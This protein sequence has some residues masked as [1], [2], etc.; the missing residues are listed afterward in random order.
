[1]GSSDVDEAY[2]DSQLSCDNCAG[3]ST[4]G[5]EAASRIAS[6]SMPQNKDCGGVVADNA[7][8]SDICITDSEYDIL[9]DW[10]DAGQPAP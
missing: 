6:G 10:L 9:M 3:G 5:A 4:K 2:S 1:M 7:A 8:N